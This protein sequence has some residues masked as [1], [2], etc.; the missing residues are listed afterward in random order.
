MKKHILVATDGSDTA[1]KAVDLAAEIAGKFGVPL[2]VAHVRQFGRPAEELARMADVEHLVEHVNRQSNLDFQLMTGT[3]GD[4]FSDK[5]PSS[6]VVRVV[7]MIGD[8]IVRRA[9]DR[10]K[11]LGATD[12]RTS[13]S[14]GDAADAILDMASD[15]GADMIVIGHRGLGRVRTLLLGSVAQKVTQQAE[16]TVVSVR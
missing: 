11:E 9:V 14:Q 13:T 3:V 1:M 2:T 4:M 8:E 6:D 12:V 5:R 10:S 15:A 16:C 7:T